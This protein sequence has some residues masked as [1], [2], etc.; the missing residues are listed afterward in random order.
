MFQSEKD[1]NFE[2]S[3]SIIHRFNLNRC[4][5]FICFKRNCDILDF[6]YGNP[7]AIIVINRHWRFILHARII[8]H[9]CWFVFTSRFDKYKNNLMVIGHQAELSVLGGKIKWVPLTAYILD[10]SS[11]KLLGRVMFRYL[12]QQ[13]IHL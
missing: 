2:I 1:C 7:C 13:S 8:M 11:T 12:V 4:N 10:V 5:S 6:M 3:S 9:L